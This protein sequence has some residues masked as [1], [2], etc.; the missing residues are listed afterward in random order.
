MKNPSAQLSYL[1]E[2]GYRLTPQRLA[3]LDVLRNSQGH[4]SPTEIYQ[5]VAQAIPGMTEATVYRTLS[6]LGEQGLVLVAH[7]GKGQLVY[8][9]AEHDH[10]HLICSQCGD[11][12]EIDHQQLK[13]LYEQFTQ[14][15]G[16]Q[17]HSIHTTFFGHCPDCLERNSREEED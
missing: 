16:Y 9:Y 10:H 6:F 12:Q 2:Q 3:I 17:I 7:L 5:R 8:E 14:K 1:R 15:T 4:L 13:D 11:M